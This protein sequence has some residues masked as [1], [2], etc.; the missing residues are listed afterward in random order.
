[1]H[2]SARWA[3]PADGTCSAYGRLRLQAAVHR[4]SVQ[5]IGPRETCMRRISLA[6]AVLV[7]LACGAT[8][9]LPAAAQ[10]DRGSPSASQIADQIDARIAK[11]KADLRLDDDQS[12]NWGGVQSALHDI[13]INRANRY[14]R[15]D[16]AAP[17]RRVTLTRHHRCVMQTQPRRHATRTRRRQPMH[18]SV[19]AAG[20]PMWPTSCAEKPII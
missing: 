18:A 16:E 7:A 17:M 9:T 13:G 10:R 5:G 1:M 15:R 8:G 12:K 19:I 6:S 11:L 4:A 20:C 14:L 3:L 2:A